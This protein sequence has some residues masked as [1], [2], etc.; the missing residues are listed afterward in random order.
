LLSLFSDCRRR[1]FSFSLCVCVG[2]YGAD[3][4]PSNFL[5]SAILSE[6]RADWSENASHVLGRFPLIRRPGSNGKIGG[7]ASG[8]GAQNSSASP[9]QPT[10]KKNH[11]PPPYFVVS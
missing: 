10:Q 1:R 2:V 4:Q 5:L 11:P 6:T 3:A 9:A 8:G 7:V